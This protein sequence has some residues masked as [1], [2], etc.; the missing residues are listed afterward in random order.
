MTT[1]TAH[2]TNAATRLTNNIN[3]RRRTAAR[4]AVHVSSAVSVTETAGVEKPTLIGEAGGH[5]TK[6]G[7]RITYPGAYARRGFS[8]MTYV[9]STQ[10]VLVPVGYFAG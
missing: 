9:G 3:A 6:S 8:N 10:Q 7:D 1:T 2:W 5:F 4:R